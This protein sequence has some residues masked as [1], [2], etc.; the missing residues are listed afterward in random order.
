MR[1]LRALGLVLLVAG[2]IAT[3]LGVLTSDIQVGL[4]LF[5]IPYLKSSTWVGGL[6]I[7]LIFAGIVVLILDGFYAIND[8]VFQTED[9]KKSSADSSKTEMG[10]VVLIGPIPIVFGSSNRAALLALI[11][12]AVFIMALLLALFF[13]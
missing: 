4:A 1:I 11:A 5:F 12:A 3:V 9:G 6:A 7:L 13:I 10:G 2:V 8:Q